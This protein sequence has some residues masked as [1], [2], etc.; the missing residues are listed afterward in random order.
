MAH[1]SLHNCDDTLRVLVCGDQM[2]LR[3]LSA[4]DE[5][6]DYL[7]NQ[8]RSEAELIRARVRS[9]QK[10]ARRRFRLRL[11]A[12]LFGRRKGQALGA[13]RLSSNL[14]DSPQ[15]QASVTLGLRNLNPASSSET[16]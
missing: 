13:P 5:N 6:L 10:W 3:S 1:A 16:S 12:V 4:L 7:A 2:R 8:N 15:P 11:R 14:I 9:R